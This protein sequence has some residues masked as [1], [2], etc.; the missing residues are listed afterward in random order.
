MNKKNLTRGLVALV[1]LLALM[2]GGTLGVNALTAPVIEA[3]QKALLGDAVLIYDQADPASSEL[4]VTADTVKTVYKDDTKQVYTLHLASFEGYTKDV[5]IELTLVL[6]YEGRI[7]S[8]NVDGS[9]ETKELDE[10]FL[11]SFVGQ[12]SALA[13]VSL[14]A[15]ATFSS[16]AIRSAVSD[17]M[18]T[19]IEN[20][21]ITAGQKTGEQLLTELVPLVYPGLVNKAGVIQGE[22]LPGSGSATKGYKAA[23]GSGSA[24]F[25]HEGDADYL[26]VA[27]V[28]GGVKVYDVEG[29]PVDDPALLSAVAELAAAVNEDRHDKQQAALARMLPEGAVLEPMQ[30][31]GLANSVTGAYSAQTEDGTLYAFAARPYG[32]SNEVME[33]YYVLDENGAIVSWRVSE[34]ILHSEYYSNYELDEASYKEGFIGLTSDT[35]TGEQ[36]Q[37]TGAT[38]TSDAVETAVHDVFEAFGLLTENR[39]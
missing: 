33:F 38:M 27:S 2:A 15:G 18:N 11:P 21:L 13:E 19:L 1:L 7:V 36:A 39:G 26:G 35:F 12:D 9:G 8:L 23:N 24:W 31:E 30:L 34:L 17:G 37:I 25:I 14:V 6:D 3:N 5:P 28:V 20:G 16:S 29:K 10:G 22:E 32:Y 4:T